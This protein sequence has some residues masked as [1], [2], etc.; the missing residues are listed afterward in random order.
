VEAE[1]IRF[2]SYIEYLQ[3]ERKELVEKLDSVVYPVLTAPS[4]I[5]SEIYLA[6]LPSNRRIRASAKKAPLLLA[7]ICSQWRATAL[8]TCGLW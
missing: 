5:I 1:V 8:S 2:Q 4:E 6:C 3:S 7:Q